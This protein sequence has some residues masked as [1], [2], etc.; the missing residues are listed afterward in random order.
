MNDN[1]IYKVLPRGGGKTRWLVRKA[2]EVAE[3]GLDVLL[4][5][6][7]NPI[8]YRDFLETMHSET[9]KLVAVH[10]LES[11][12]DF[13]SMNENTALFIDGL[14]ESGISTSE[15][16]AAYSIVNKAY[17]TI[18]GKEE[19]ECHC[20]GQCGHEDKDPDQLTIFDIC[21]VNK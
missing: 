15:L 13:S 4:Y 11:L 10:T 17:I 3:S 9:G 19:H 6:G 5:T 21:E 16:N 18:T 2:V 1:V 20:K 8:R 14:I 12:T 7:K